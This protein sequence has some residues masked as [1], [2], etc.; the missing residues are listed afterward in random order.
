MSA[1]ANLEVKWTIN[2]K[3]KVKKEMENL[4]V[5]FSAVDFGK[6]FSHY[7]VYKCLNL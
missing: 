1:S 2:P 4:L 6:S 7:F 5:L 3:T